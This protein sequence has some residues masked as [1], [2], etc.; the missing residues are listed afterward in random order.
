MSLGHL[1]CGSHTFT[2]EKIGTRYMLAASGHWSI[3]STR[4]TS[5]RFT[6]CRMRSRPSRQ[7]RREIRSS[8]LGPGQPEEGAR[9]A[10]RS[11]HDTS[12]FQEGVR[13]QGAG[14]SDP[15]PD[16]NGRGLGRQPRQGRDLS[17]HHARRERRHDGLQA[18]RQGCA[19]RRLLVR[20]PLRCR[21]AITRKTRTTPIRSTIS[22]RKKSPDGSIAIQFGGCDGKIPNCLPIMKGWNYTVRLY[23]PRDEILN[24]K[25]KFPE[26]QPA[27]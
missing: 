12:R 2:K 3:R 1:R 19:G 6:H 11:C 7:A 14:R 20:Q 8:E 17:Q 15:P 16:R 27:S 25:W 5:H 22:P 23:R 18:Q 24:G 21:R 9:R 10:A 26:P 13:H 4:R